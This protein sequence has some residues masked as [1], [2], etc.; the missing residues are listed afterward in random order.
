ML[1]SVFGLVLLALFGMGI[2]VAAL[3]A[4]RVIAWENRVLTKLADALREYRLSLEE[5]EKLLEP[6]LVAAPAAET[7]APARLVATRGHQ[8]GSRAA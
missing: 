3:S 5:E 8:Q 7:L 1:S 6:G 4:T 2:I